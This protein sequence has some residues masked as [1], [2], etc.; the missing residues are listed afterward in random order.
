MEE[1][2]ILI[3]GGGPAG[4]STALYLHRLRPDLTPRIL[5]LEKEHYPRPKLCAGGLVADAEILLQS[6]GL[7]VSEIPH[8]DVKTAHFDYA[9]SGLAISLPGTH[10]LRII[11]RDELDAWLAAKAQE[12]GLE[13]RTG[14]TVRDVK[15][16][17]AGVTVETSAGT[18]RARLVIGADG[19]NGIT[20]RCVLPNAPIFTARLLEVLTPLNGNGERPERKHDAY[21]DFFPVP[22]GIAG[23]VWDFPTQVQGQPMRCWGV[24]DSNLLSYV[25]R[26]P[27]QAPLR[28]EMAR[29]GYNLDDFELKGH[30]IRWF[31]PFNPFSVPGVLLVGD[32]AGADPLFGEG[33]SLALGYGFVAAGEVLEAFRQDDFRLTG[34]RRRLLMSPLGGTLIARWLIGYLVYTFRWEWFQFL[35]WRVLQ[36]VVMLVAWLFV[37]NWGK[38]LVQ[39]RPLS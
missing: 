12:R 29:L 22:D 30:P 39:R 16:D 24:Y 5:L 11:R 26:P 3:L 36:P 33:I 31:D 23:Y 6:L 34:Y 38:R 21:F 13:I 10:A 8:M 2:D 32:A 15:P 1:K 20:R 4:L 27:L 14:I 35:L 7:D 25:K 28:A 18:F 9:G 37:L 17:P 19:S